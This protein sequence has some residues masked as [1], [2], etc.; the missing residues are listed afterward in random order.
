MATNNVDSFVLGKDN[1]PAWFALLDKEGQVLY[2]YTKD[3][4]LKSITIKR[5]V[6]YMTAQLGDT[7]MNMSGNVIVVPKAAADKYMKG[8]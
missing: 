3:R 4:K 2:E 6:K 5:P 8:V 1:Y 7:I